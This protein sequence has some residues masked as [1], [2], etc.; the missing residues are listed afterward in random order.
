MIDMDWSPHLSQAC[1]T[2]PAI[3]VALSQPHPDTTLCTVT[4][5]VDWSTRLLVKNALTHARQDDNVHLIIDLSAVTSMDCA[6]PYTLLEAR[7]P[8]HLHGGG[9]L[10]VIIDPDSPAIPELHLVA[11]Q[12]AFDVHSTLA[13]ALCACTS[14]GHQ[15]PETA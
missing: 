13:D 3:T 11:L 9:H 10:A 14:T 8:H 2:T 12:A 15:M 6:G 7:F 1:A 4:G 5:T